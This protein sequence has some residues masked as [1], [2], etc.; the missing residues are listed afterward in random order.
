MFYLFPCAELSNVALE[1]AMLRAGH[2][3]CCDLF[4]TKLFLDSV[5]LFGNK[6]DSSGSDMWH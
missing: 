6:G 3:T 2:M 4:Q 1:V 5:K